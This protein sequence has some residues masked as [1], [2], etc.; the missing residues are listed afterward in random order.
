[1]AAPRFKH[2]CCRLT[3]ITT[4]TVGDS[5]SCARKGN[6]RMI[7]QKCNILYPVDFSN[8]CVLAAHH[9]K[10]WVDRFGATLNTLHVVDA[11]ALAL[12]L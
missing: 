9:V 5:V 4:K 10:T 1:M 8:R 7:S 2:S 6:F 12:L 3:T 11:D